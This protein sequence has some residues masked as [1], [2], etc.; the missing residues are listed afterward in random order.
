MADLAPYAGNKHIDLG[1][2]HCSDATVRG[3]E[4]ALATLA[5]NIIENAVNYTPR[6]GRV[7]V[8]ILNRDRA[9]LL[10][11]A[12]NG[13]GIDPESRDRVFER[14]Y[15]DIRHSSL[16][17]GSG[18]GLSIVKRIADIHHAD[19]VLDAPD[20]GSGLIFQVAFPRA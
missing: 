18:L 10:I 2:D 17:R 8:S 14:F 15:H 4:S 5:R 13:P 1:M 19:I 12:D 9:V 3:V 20:Q 6:G 7:N 11:V 16:V